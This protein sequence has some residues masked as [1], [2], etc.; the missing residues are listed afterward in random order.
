MH[1]DGRLTPD[2]CLKSV[3]RYSRQNRGAA[4]ATED[5]LSDPK[6]PRVSQIGARAGV[7]SQ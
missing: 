4:S 5:P 1:A 7:C 6:R 3:D 2:R